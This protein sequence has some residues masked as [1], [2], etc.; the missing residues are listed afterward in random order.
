MCLLTVGVKVEASRTGVEKVTVWIV[1][2]DASGAPALTRWEVG[3]M[4]GE[5]D[6]GYHYELACSLASDAGYG[7]PMVAFDESDPAGRTMVSLMGMQS[8]QTQEEV[9]GEE[10]APEWTVP[11]TTDATL[12]ATVRVRAR[13]EEEAIEVARKYVAEDGGACLLSLD[14]GHYKGRSDFYCG[15]RMAVE[16]VQACAE[17]GA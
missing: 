12:S 9:P 6:V 14:E 2:P 16:M 4:P 17:E 5:M 8:I 1:A 10:G 3:V 11:V 7:E 13:D 15:D